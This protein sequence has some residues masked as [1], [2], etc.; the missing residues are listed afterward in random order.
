MTVKRRKVVKRRGEDF[1]DELE[2][3]ELRLESGRALSFRIA[4]E[5]PPIPDG[6]HERVKEAERTIGR[7]TFWL[8]QSERA[9]QIAKREEEK[10]D[11][12][13]AKE[14]Y[15][16]RRHIQQGLVDSVEMPTENNIK[17]RILL[18]DQL[19]PQKARV[20]SAW[21]RY[22]ALR[23]LTTALEHRSH[24]IRLL[25]KRDADARAHG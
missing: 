11:R 23:S 15:A 10:A 5:L 8:H 3:I 17:A 19:E 16:Q 4:D 14:Y 25:I 2:A 24:L 21:R 6:E 9:R 20:R 12:A 18:D 7:L 13:W 1:L 22:G